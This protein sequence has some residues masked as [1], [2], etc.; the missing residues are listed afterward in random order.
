MDFSST[1][2][3]ETRAGLNFAPAVLASF[4]F[5]GEFGLHPVKQNPTFV[6]YESPAVFVNI[7]HGRSSF[8]LGVEVGRLAES[9]LP[10]T[11]F[12]IVNAAD[13]ADAEGFGHHV[14]FQVGT[15]E[16]VAQFVPK[17]ASLIEKYGV[18][19]LRG[20]EDAYRDIEQRRSQ[21]IVQNQKEQNLR[22]TRA[23]VEVA[24]QAKDFA[25]VVE[26]FNPVRS[27]LTEIETRKLS[28]AQKHLS[29][30]DRLLLLPRMLR[31]K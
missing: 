22:N 28:Y 4:R 20:Q 12:E 21:H 5:L 25:K 13:A 24:W 27:D 18:P 30:I 1:N 31:R 15:A 8:E 26:Q 3:S 29:V 6:R 16:G 17:L 7:Y 10:V 2:D 14:M 23:K 9:A 11:L 19:F